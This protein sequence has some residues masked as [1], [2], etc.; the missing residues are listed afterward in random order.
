MYLRFVLFHLGDS[1]LDKVFGAAGKVRRRAP[2]G[3]AG[4]PGS[5][6]SSELREVGAWGAGRY[7]SREMRMTEK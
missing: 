5:V 7:V 4:E 1:G 2:G 3:A 6:T